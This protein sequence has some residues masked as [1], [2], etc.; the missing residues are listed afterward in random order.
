[1]K[2]LCYPGSGLNKGDVAK[3][4]CRMVDEMKRW[5]AE[6]HTVTIDDLGT[7][8]L[9]IGVIRYRFLRKTSA[10]KKISFISLLFLQQR[11]E[12]DRLNKIFILQEFCNIQQPCFHWLPLQCSIL[13]SAFLGL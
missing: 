1:M 11:Y 6:G 3:V 2:K 8:S 5:L 10:I 9:S 13:C 7:F 4:M 12:E